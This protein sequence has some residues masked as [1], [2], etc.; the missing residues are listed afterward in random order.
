M[1]QKQ[2]WMKFENRIKTKKNSNSKMD[3]NPKNGL[4][5]LKLFKIRKL[6]C[7]ENDY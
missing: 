4:N 6:N 5:S 1:D 3:Q 2:K 7:D